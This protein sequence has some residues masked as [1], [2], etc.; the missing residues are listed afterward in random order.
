[1]K[2]H[3]T[4]FSYFAVLAIV[5]VCLAASTPAYA[6]GREK[7]LYQFYGPQEQVQLPQGGLTA[8]RAGNYYGAVSQRK[9]NPYGEIFVLVTGANGKWSDHVIYTFTG[10]SDGMYPNPG[11]I[12]DVAGNLY[13]AANQ[14]GEYGVGTIFELSPNPSGTWTET[15]LYNFNYNNGTDGIYPGS[16]LTVDAA[17]NL[18]GTTQFGGNYQDPYCA[19][20]GCGAIFKMT[21]NPDGTWKE[22]TLYGLLFIDGSDPESKV[23]FDAAGNLYGMTRGG[24]QYL[25]CSCGTVFQ[26][27]L[28]ADGTYLFHRLYSFQGGTDGYDPY[29]NA[30]VLDGKGNLYGSTHWGGNQGC[31]THY[32]TGCGTVFEL[33]AQPNGAWTETVLHVF[34]NAAGD[35]ELP[36]SVKFDAA[37]SL[38]GVTAGGGAYG[39]GEFFEMKPA[40]KGQWT[41]GI[42]YSFDG[43]YG[44][45]AYPAGDLVTDAAGNLYGLASLPGAWGAFFRIKP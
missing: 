37:G 20:G 35:G 16:G 27:A 17:G 6:S 8:D 43:Y 42:K 19:P 41:Y 14:G 38:Y 7:V 5:L 39:A 23:I 45:A 9:G 12:F 1:M 29:T 3:R 25:S 13:G 11:F 30:P 44:D 36:F 22:S 15:T 34:G 21:Q 10:G 31:T 18:Y 32:F 28:Q 26:L 4:R 24:G 33:T 40:R 2:P